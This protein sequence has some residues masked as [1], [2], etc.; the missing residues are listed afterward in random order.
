[1]LYNSKIMQIKFQ[2]IFETIA[3]FYFEILKLLLLCMAF[4]KPTFLRVI[5]KIVVKLYK[6]D[7]SEMAVLSYNLAL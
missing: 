7:I 3:S 6:L 1:M 4:L 2:T 5:E